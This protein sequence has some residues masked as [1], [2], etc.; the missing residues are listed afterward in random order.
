LEISKALTPTSP[1][2]RYYKIGLSGITSF[3]NVNLLVNGKITGYNFIATKFSE[4]S[5]AWYS[6]GV[7]VFSTVKLGLFIVKFE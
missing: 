6:K 3:F 5:A 1:P 2:T 7:S 4:V